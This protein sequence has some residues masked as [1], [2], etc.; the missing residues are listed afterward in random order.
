M[1]FFFLLTINKKNL[2]KKKIIMR[3]FLKY[4]FFLIF[5]KDINN[6]LNV[7][8][9]FGQSKT[10]SAEILFTHKQFGPMVE[11]TTVETQTCAHQKRILNVLNEH[12]NST[13]AW[14]NNLCHIKVFVRDADCDLNAIWLFVNDFSRREEIISLSKYHLSC[15]SKYV[16]TT[17]AKASKNHSVD[18]V[19]FPNT[20][21]FQ[22]FQ[23]SVVFDDL[24]VAVEFSVACVQVMPQNNMRWHKVCDKFQKGFPEF[25]FALNRM[26]YKCNST[27]IGNMYP[28]EYP[29]GSFEPSE[30]SISYFQQ[31]TNAL[32]PFQKTTPIIPL[33]SSSSS[34][35]S[36]LLSSSTNSSFLF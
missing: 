22:M 31:I 8:N 21:V 14:C 25:S 5:T 35:T 20:C 23:P 26:K 30:Q 33:T 13:V 28:T 32:N 27:A 24:M 12:I 1:F 4:S 10:C 19:S 2:K 34:I 7:I 11:V 9:N 18:I 17:I 3:V 36:S 16:D 15:S 29:A 6:I